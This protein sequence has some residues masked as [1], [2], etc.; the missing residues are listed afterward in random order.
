MNVK[1]DDG[2]VAVTLSRRNLL[3][4]LTE[5]DSIRANDGR[6]GQG[7]RAILSRRVPLDEVDGIFL[8]VEAQED[9]VHYG[10]RKPGSLGMLRY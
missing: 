3:E 2:P 6:M 9:D 10:E 7:S 8:T 5:L 4:L 1:L